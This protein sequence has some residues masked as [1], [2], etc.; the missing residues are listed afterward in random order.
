M[1]YV[2]DTIH[3][4]HFVKMW[5]S[6]CK[7]TFHGKG[8]MWH[9]LACAVKCHQKAVAQWNT[10]LFIIFFHSVVDYIKSNP[11]SLPPLASLETANWKTLFFI[12]HPQEDQHFRNPASFAKPCNTLHTA[13]YVA[14]PQHEALARSLAAFPASNL[15]TPRENHK[16]KALLQIQRF[17]PQRK[18]GGGL[19]WWGFFS[20]S[21]GIFL[22]KW[23]LRLCQ[24]QVFLGLFPAAP[25]LAG[26]VAI[27]LALIC[28]VGWPAGRAEAPPRLGGLTTILS[29]VGNIFALLF[30]GRTDAAI[31]FCKLLQSAGG[32]ASVTP[33]LD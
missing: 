26:P 32:E 2:F 12:L 15:W 7:N 5:L 29:H 10:S 33:F 18:T 13:T 27:V 9:N 14:A 8:A 23:P 6:F 24:Y 28:K 1:S 16:T 21:S 25:T 22:S 31:G 11:S 19:F 20:Q 17:R 4:K 3:W 30:R